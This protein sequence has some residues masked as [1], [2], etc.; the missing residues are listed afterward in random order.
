MHVNPPSISMPLSGSLILQLLDHTCDRRLGR[1]VCL[2]RMTTIIS[3]AVQARDNTYAFAI[4]S[5]FG[6]SCSNDLK[7]GLGRWSKTPPFKIIF[8]ESSDRRDAMGLH[9]QLAH[10]AL[11]NIYILLTSRSYCRIDVWSCCL[12]WCRCPCSSWACP[13]GH[14]LSLRIYRTCTRSILGL[15]LLGGSLNCIISSSLQSRL[16]CVIIPIADHRFLRHLRNGDLNAC[17][18]ATSFGHTEDFQ[19]SL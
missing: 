9:P 18:I 14:R 4:S 8:G 12:N 19:N 7:D 13:W 2:D 10:K 1:S 3:F 5:H 16:Y 15:N 11:S 6:C 17:A